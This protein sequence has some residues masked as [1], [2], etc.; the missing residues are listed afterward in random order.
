[1][2]I[3]CHGLEYVGCSR[4]S[5]MEDLVLLTPLYEEHFTKFK[6]STHEKI[7]TEYNRLRKA[8]PQLVLDNEGS[9]NVC[10]AAGV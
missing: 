9:E 4:V 7:R 10:S 6:N 8:F 5:K 3:Y 1:M 2:S